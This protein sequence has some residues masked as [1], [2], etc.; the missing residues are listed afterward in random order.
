MLETRAKTLIG[1]K[2]PKTAAIASFFIPGLGQIYSGDWKKGTGF[3]LIGAIFAMF[4]FYLVR[5]DPISHMF[6]ATLVASI[7]L[8]LFWI[9]NMHDAYNTVK[10]INCT[11]K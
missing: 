8:I 5:M 10:E 9:S 4:E 6:G 3:F 1:K 11:K 2:N 7:S